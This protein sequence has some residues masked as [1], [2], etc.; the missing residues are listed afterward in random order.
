MK[1][2]DFLAK[3]YDYNSDEDSLNGLDY[4]ANNA[5]EEQDKLKNKKSSLN[6]LFLMIPKRIKKRN[7]NK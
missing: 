2:Q 3:N 7:E 6:F 1:I 5:K 4:F